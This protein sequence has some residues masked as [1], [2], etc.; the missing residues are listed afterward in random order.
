MCVQALS[1]TCKSVK[2][3]LSS[4]QPTDPALQAE[5][6]TATKIAGNF[7]GTAMVLTGYGLH[8]DIRDEGCWIHSTCRFCDTDFCR[9]N[10]TAYLDDNFSKQNKQDRTSVTVDSFMGAIRNIE[11]TC[12]YFGY[13]VYGD[14]DW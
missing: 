14:E 9:N 3:I 5:P 11:T 7:P 13:D 10:M 8:D 4:N 1:A 12:I 2:D 6:N